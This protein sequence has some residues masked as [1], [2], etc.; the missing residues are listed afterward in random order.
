V[1]G[2]GESLTA[3][4]P[5]GME[6]RGLGCW[7][8][9]TWLGVTAVLVGA[10]LSWPIRALA[11]EGPHRPPK[12]PAAAAEPGERAPAKPEGAEPA[13]APKEPS[14]PEAPGPTE[15]APPEHPPEQPAPPAANEIVPE[16]V[17]LPGEEAGAPAPPAE[18]LA[19]AEQPPEV[20]APEAGAGTGQAPEAP[21]IPTASG[22]ATIETLQR[23]RHDFAVRGSRIQSELAAA[24]LKLT[25]AR[26]DLASLRKQEARE[27]SAVAD[28]DRTEAEAVALQKAA[29]KAYEEYSGL[30]GQARNKRTTVSGD[31]AAC[32]ADLQAAQQQLQLLGASESQP[33]T[34][35]LV[36]QAQLLVRSLREQADDAK[37]LRSTWVTIEGV[38]WEAFTTASQLSE[39]IV[40]ALAVSGQRSLWRRSEE[41]ISL[42][43]AV[44]AGSDVGALFRWAGNRLTRSVP[45][46]AGG[47]ARRITTLRGLIGFLLRLVACALL[48]YTGAYGFRQLRAYVI[49]R[50]RSPE[51]PEAPADLAGLDPSMRAGL[52]IAR[53]LI[54]FMVGAVV[55]QLTRMS[56]D[57]LLF[58]VT[59]LASACG[60][61][62]LTNLS[63]IVFAPDDAHRRVPRVSDDHAR[64][65]YRTL[66]SFFRLSAVFVPILAGFG[67]FSYERR[68]VVAAV[69]FVYG[70][71]ALGHL[72]A[73]S[74]PKG[75]LKQ[76]VPD[77]GTFA[78]RTARR[79]VAA[80]P[81][82]LLVLGALALG[83]HGLGYTNLSAFLARTLPT[84]VLVIT[85]CWILHRTYIVQVEERLATLPD[86]DRGQADWHVF[87]RAGRPLF[88]LLER[89]GIVVLAAAIILEASGLPARHLHEFSAALARPLFTVKGAQVSTY[90]L[91]TAVL[92]IVLSVLIGRI[93]REMLREAASLRRRYDQGVRYAIAS[94]VYYVIVVAAVFWAVP[95]AGFNWSVLAVFAGVAGIGIGFGLQDIAR[96]FISGIIILLEQP[97]K[98]GDFVDLGQLRGTVTQISIRSTTIR[99]QDNIYVIVPNAEFIG[100]QITNYSH[101]D[102]K[103]RLQLNVG[104]SYGSDMPRVRGVLEKVAR[105]HPLTLNDPAPE[106]R[107]MTFGDS[108]V[109]FQ[110]LAWIAEP[111]DMPRTMSELHYA[112]WDAL[113]EGGIE[114]PF[115]QRDIHIRSDDTLAV[116]KPPDEDR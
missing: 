83:A 34:D 9:R 24:E 78:S 88:G 48:V 95:V 102:L 23:L 13:P 30:Y 25:N 91:L 15:A 74:L 5:G 112:V 104:V 32:E 71:V 38:A 43:T 115:P 8:C 11:Q 93:I 64:L 50:R 111:S 16:G 73:L 63:E 68:D 87:G 28:G 56:G 39:D 22:W 54:A 2:A 85:G 114:I 96:N 67:I 70:A 17:A 21:T 4:G 41:W 90:A 103:V 49:A 40:S 19:P 57:W 86:V 97:I 47:F 1:R 12:P 66:R 94:F 89:V 31:V 108:S 29:A 101:R 79:A 99:T 45:R 44:S 76:L 7:R 105:D 6:A 116:R 81:S 46:W 55:L 27:P 107:M 37:T 52:G 26:S 10:V 61:M 77:R 35:P 98:V 69:E 42:R 80:A 84:T 113:A 62:V 109:N 20:P 36:E 3:S 106:A 92:V 58:W 59:V 72:L 14:A 82:A 60:C 33:T 18:G 65:L 51:A 100:G 110:L 53:G 75:G